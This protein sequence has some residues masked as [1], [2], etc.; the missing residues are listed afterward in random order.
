MQFPRQ[1]CLIDFLPRSSASILIVLL[2]SIDVLPNSV[3][4]FLIVLLYSCAV[5][6]ISV[7][8]HLI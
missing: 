3:A 2:S 7:L 4:S 6:F 1:D 5:F 8:F